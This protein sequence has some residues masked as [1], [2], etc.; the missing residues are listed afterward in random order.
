MTEKYT[1]HSISGTSTAGVA[2]AITVGSFGVQFD[3]GVITP[4]S[5]GCSIVAL[6]HAHLDHMASLPMWFDQW[7]FFNKHTK[8]SSVCLCPAPMVDPLKD[9]VDAYNKIATL[10]NQRGGFS[11]EWVPVF[12][13]DRY[14][15]R[16]SKNFLQ[17]IETQ[18]GCPSFAWAIMKPVTKRKDRYNGLSTLETHDLIKAGRDVLE[19]KEAPQVVY[20]GDT[21]RCD[22]LERPEFIEANTV[23]TECTYFEDDHRSKARDRHHLHLDDIVE[24]LDIWE[25]DNVVITHVTKSTKIHEAK[26]MMAAR[27]PQHMDRIH[28]IR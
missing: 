23:I 28:F 9:L 16:E 25:A 26:E 10:G 24:L 15:I 1:Q 27:C 18:H 19:T 3:L 20:V 17:A 7:H 4:E 2:T 12:D 13:G 14:Q 5:M 8:N 21:L 6:S 11:A 22:A